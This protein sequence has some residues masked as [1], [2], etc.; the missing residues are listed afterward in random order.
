MQIRP[1][2]KEE[3]KSIAQLHNVI[4][5][6]FFMTS[7]GMD[8]LNGHYKSVLSHPGS[9]CYVADNDGELC[10]FVLGRA[11]AKNGLK[12]VIKS[13]PFQFALL[14]L[15][16]L[17]VNPKSLIRVIKNIKKTGDKNIQD[18]QDYAE[19]GLIGV[20]PD[21]KQT[22]VGHQLF[23][24]FCK[25]AIENGAKQVSLTTDYYDNDLVLNSYRR[26]GFREYYVF[27]AYPER[28]M[29]RLIKDIS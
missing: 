23:D 17:F 28:K 27:T 5:P 7:L 15:K 25:S 19:I 8:Y 26:W 1:A 24:A 4:F 13:Y 10:G 2:L 20:L 9:I 18:K 12:N 22:G 6:D 14:G 21:V 29:Y 16:V 11:D 3:Y